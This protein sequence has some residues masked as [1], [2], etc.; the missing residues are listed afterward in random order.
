M[1]YEFSWLQPGVSQTE[2][3]FVFQPMDI[4]S[5]NYITWI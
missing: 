5:M 3:I 2:I 4:K 1:T